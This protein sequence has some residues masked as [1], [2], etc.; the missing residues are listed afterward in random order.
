MEMA[1]RRVFLS[2]LNDDNSKIEGYVELLESSPTHIKFKRGFET[3][4]LP[5]GRILKL[6]EVSS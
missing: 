4:T 2:W 5:I 6:K 3:I 1:L